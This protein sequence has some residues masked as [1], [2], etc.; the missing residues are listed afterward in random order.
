[1]NSVFFMS[2]ATGIFPFVCKDIPTKSM[3]NRDF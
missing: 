3:G 1:M 2:Y